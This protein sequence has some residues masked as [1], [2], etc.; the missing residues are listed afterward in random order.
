MYTYIC[1]REN[2]VQNI[3]IALLF[4]N[5]THTVRCYIIKYNA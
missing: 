3:Q 4:V 5:D 2:N 1:I